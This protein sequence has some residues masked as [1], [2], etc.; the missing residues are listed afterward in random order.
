[1]IAYACDPEGGGEHWLG[2]GWARE[3]SRNHEVVLFTTP[4][5]KAALERAAPACGIELHCLEVPTWVRW[6]SGLPLIGN[7]WLRKYG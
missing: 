4:K 2:W 7:G 3:A 5:A 6:L 1:M